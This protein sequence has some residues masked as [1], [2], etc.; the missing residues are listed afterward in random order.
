MWIRRRNDNFTNVIIT[1]IL[2]ECVLAPLL[3]TGGL[4][5]KK[6][7]T[8]LADAT[9]ISSDILAFQLRVH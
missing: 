7:V 4:I 9:A 5:A 3:V 2:R 1:I 8:V 6:L